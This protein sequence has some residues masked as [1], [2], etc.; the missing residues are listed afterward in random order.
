[1][2]LLSPRRFVGLLAV[3]FG[4][5][6]APLACLSD[7][8]GAQVDRSEVLDTSSP[9]EPRFEPADFTALASTNLFIRESSSN[10]TIKNVVL[11][12]T[13]YTG[14]MVI[15]SG[16]E[17]LTKIVFQRWSLINDYLNDQNAKW[18]I[19]CY[20]EKDPVYSNIYIDGV[21]AEHAVYMH[22]PQGMVLIQDL[23]AFDIGAQGW[24]QT[25]RGAEG[26]DPLGYLN[27]GTHRLE[28]CT[29]R[30][31]GQPR[32]Y[33]RAS[34]AVSFF[35]RQEGGGS[36]PRMYWDCPVE[37]IDV[38][39]EHDSQNQYELR[40]ALLVEHRPS[41][42]VRGGYSNYVGKSD[43]DFWHIH[44]VR[45][46]RVENHYAHA[47]TGKSIDIDWADSVVFTSIDFDGGDAPVRIDG[48]YMGTSDDEINWTR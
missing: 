9:D 47:P 44:R 8:S 6:L 46:V 38:V 13:S 31:C 28:R 16:K 10:S 4:C 1:M 34:Y 24:Q 37:L 40:G 45:D 17:T 14:P 36:T 32:G 12:G 18:A 22:N 2:Q 11:K 20:N 30:K 3:L 26:N 42:L 7:K 41:L 33:G 15:S 39:I 43:R 21:K 23:F 25:F 27:T 35:G 5:A 29:F 19:L 48:V